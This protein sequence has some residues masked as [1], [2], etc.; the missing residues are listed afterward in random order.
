MK[1][2]IDT[3]LWVSFLIGK[4]LK[5]LNTLFSTAELKIY[6]CDL[7]I[8]EIISATEKPKVRKYISETDVSAVLE[9]IDSC[10]THV[11]LSKKAISPV[12][13]VNDL[14]LLS[15]AE[16]VQADFILT[17]D[18]DLLSLQSHRQTKIVTFRAFEAIIEV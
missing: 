2:V 13:D 17:G 14:Y 4:K 7:L 12:R 16:T 3:N 9:L 10:C 1:I 5:G 15:L 8:D 18:K 11:G 6:V